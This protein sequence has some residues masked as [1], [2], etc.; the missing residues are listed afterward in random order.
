M[1][2]RDVNQKILDSLIDVYSVQ[3][4][5]SDG[6]GSQFFTTKSVYQAAGL[7]KAQL[8]PTIAGQ[9]TVTVNISNAYTAA[10][11]TLPT[12]IKGSPFTVTFDSDPTKSTIETFPKIQIAGAP[13]TFTIQSRDSD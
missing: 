10:Y 12:T 7:Y 9:Y 2:S 13:Y 1:Q 4:T 6:G 8:I 11:P 3:F 5:R